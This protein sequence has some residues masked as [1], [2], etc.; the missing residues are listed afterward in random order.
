MTIQESGVLQDG[1]TYAR[2]LGITETVEREGMAKE[3]SAE[4]IEIG[5]EV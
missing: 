2:V 3:V 5:G 4:K 1:T